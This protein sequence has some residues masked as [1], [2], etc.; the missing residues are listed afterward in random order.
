MYHCEFSAMYQKVHLPG[1]YNRKERQNYLV[2]T[3]KMD[4]FLAKI[5]VKQVK[6]GNRVD[7][8]WTPAAYT[9]ALQV[10]NENFGGGLTKEQVRS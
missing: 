6:E 10:L 4:H 7:G 1:S 3:T 8:T 2:W 5:L 9:A